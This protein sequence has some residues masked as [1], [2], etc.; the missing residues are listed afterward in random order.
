VHRHLIPVHFPT[1]NAEVLEIRESLKPS[2]VIGQTRWSAIDRALDL[3][4]GGTS[5][6][7]QALFSELFPHVFRGVEL[8]AMGWLGYSERKWF[9]MW[10]LA[11]YILGSSLCPWLATCAA[12]VPSSRDRDLP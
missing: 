10:I 11:W 3:G 8:R 4:Q 5:L 1:V 6:V 2:R 12:G 7:C 9:I